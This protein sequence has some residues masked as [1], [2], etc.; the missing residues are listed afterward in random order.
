MQQLSIFSE[1]DDKIQEKLE[2]LDFILSNLEVEH[3]KSGINKNREYALV[4]FKNARVAL[5]DL[6]EHDIDS[7]MF[8]KLVKELEERVNGNNERK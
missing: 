2:L 5:Y 1:E 4:R 8:N 7:E 3:F 6:F